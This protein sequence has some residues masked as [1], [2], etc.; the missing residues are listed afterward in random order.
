MSAYP[1]ITPSAFEGSFGGGGGYI[2]TPWGDIYWGGEPPQPQPEPA[3]SL[4]PDWWKQH[5]DAILVGALVALLV[6]IAVR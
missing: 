1:G 5:S 6:Y 4:L 2:R 3:P